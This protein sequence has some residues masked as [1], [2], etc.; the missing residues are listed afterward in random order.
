M[1][2]KKDDNRKRASG[3]KTSFY[4]FGGPD[5]RMTLESGES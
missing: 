2:K 4:T 1:V 5:S 3:S